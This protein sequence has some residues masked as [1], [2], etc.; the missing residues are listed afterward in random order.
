MPNRQQPAGQK[1]P[2]NLIGRFPLHRCCGIQRMAGESAQALAEAMPRPLPV[3][4][5]FQSIN[6]EYLNGCAVH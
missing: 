5:Y 4:D 3:D 2:M 6:D 1:R